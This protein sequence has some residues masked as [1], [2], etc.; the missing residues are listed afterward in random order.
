M[1]FWDSSALV[2]ILVR[3]PA[4]GLV[5][6][7]FE[8]DRRRVTVWWETPV[9]CAAALSRLRREGQLDE[10]QETLSLTV[11]GGLITTWN[12]IIPSRDLRETAE[13]LVRVHPLKAG[14]ALQL[15]AALSWAS[16]AP[17]RRV[18]LVS[19]D[20]RLREPALREGFQVLPDELES[21]R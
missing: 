18:G 6:T 4:S 20:Q 10:S 16:H 7:L 9:E 1:S 13:R 19:L 15:A 17:R 12:E 3:Q 2:P 5:R 21:K 8:G 11:L 14:D